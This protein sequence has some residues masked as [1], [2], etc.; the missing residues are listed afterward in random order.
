MNE[1]KP[2]YWDRLFSS[3]CSK[4]GITAEMVEKVEK[5]FGVSLRS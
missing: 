2:L 4:E 5:E 3:L 1:V